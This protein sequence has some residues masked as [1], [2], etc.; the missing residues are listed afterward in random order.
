MQRTVCSCAR[1]HFVL[2]NVCNVQECF[3]NYDVYEAVGA[4]L[5]TATHLLKG[6]GKIC[7]G[8]SHANQTVRTRTMEDLT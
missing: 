4:V 7:G 2:V 6:S 3:T 1:F 5:R 8:S